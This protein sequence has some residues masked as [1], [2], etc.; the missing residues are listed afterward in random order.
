MD[1]KF[2]S[3]KK[4]EMKNSEK[5]TRR[6]PRRFEMIEER[7]DIDKRAADFIK[8]FRNQLRIERAESL[9]RFHEMLNREHVIDPR[10]TRCKSIQWCSSIKA[11]DRSRKESRRP[12]PVLQLSLNER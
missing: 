3:S 8:N 10:E 1:K 2:E 6:I 11:C 12:F 4:V 9:K 7:T 5:M